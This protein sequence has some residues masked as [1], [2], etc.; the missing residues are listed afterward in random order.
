[1]NAHFKTMQGLY[2]ALADGSINRDDVAYCDENGGIY[3]HDTWYGLPETASENGGVNSS[4]DIGYH[5]GVIPYVQILDANRYQYDLSDVLKKDGVYTFL[6]EYNY[7]I[8]FKVCILVIDGSAFVNTKNTT[9]ISITLVD[10]TDNSLISLR[11]R[12][13]SPDNILRIDASTI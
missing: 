4:Y 8:Q 12:I 13:I 2:N 6:F 7:D 3:T 10:K 5:E 1:M 11:I 9:D